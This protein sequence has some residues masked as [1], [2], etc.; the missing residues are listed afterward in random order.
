[1]DGL[2]ATVLHRLCKCMS[3]GKQWIRDFNGTIFIP[4]LD[5]LT[6]FLTIKFAHAVLR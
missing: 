2:T 5:Q 4:S 1:M 3:C 6:N